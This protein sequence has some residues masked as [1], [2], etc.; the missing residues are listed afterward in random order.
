M[1]M[2]LRLENAC[3]A[4]AA[5]AAYWHWDAGWW[6]F[7]ILVLVPDLSMLGYI[8]GP[9]IGAVA[10]NAVHSL[11]GVGLLLLAGYLAAWELAVPVALIWAFHIFLDR[12]LGYGLKY[13]T[14]FQDT[15]LGR[16]GQPVTK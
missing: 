13:R 7:L 5:L 12:A 11:I 1:T 14:G 10:Y 3:L 6:L 9:R 15:H 4:L 2:F 16:I 8:F